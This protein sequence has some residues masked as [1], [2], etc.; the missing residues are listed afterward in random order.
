M[1]NPVE[2][3]EVRLGKE[4]VE[5]F[6]MGKIRKGLWK[7]GEGAVERIFSDIFNDRDVEAG[8][9]SYYSK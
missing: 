8:A 6:F 5:Y 4:V 3:I 1:R 9:G 2:K 7:R